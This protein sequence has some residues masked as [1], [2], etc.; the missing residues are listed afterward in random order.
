VAGVGGIA[1]CPS[2][3]FWAVGL[4]SEKFLFFV[5]KFCPKCKILSTNNVLC[6]KFAVFYRKIATS[7]PDYFL[8]HDA[9][10]PKRYYKGSNKKVVGKR[11]EGKR[12]RRR[13]EQFNS[14]C[15]L[16][17]RPTGCRL[18]WKRACENIFITIHQVATSACFD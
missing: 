7:C 16:Q 13:V 17:Y 15:R 6:R 18:T 5:E 12:K 1:D 11:Y 2:S 10:V 3:E 14:V 9:A 8:T 4:L